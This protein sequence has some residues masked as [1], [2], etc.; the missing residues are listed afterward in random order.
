MFSAF[1]MGITNAVAAEIQAAKER[2]AKWALMPPEEAAKAR[3][4]WKQ[5]IEANIA[6]QRALEIAKASRPRNWL[7]TLLGIR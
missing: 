3:Q 7:E 6:H 1:A 2:E 5:Q 4:E